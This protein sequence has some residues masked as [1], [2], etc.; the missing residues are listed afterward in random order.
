M[1]TP[2]ENAQFIAEKLAEASR[3]LY[4]AQAAVRATMT[5]VET[6]EN[7]PELKN[8]SLEAVKGS[9]MVTNMALAPQVHAWEG[10]AQDRAKN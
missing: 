5:A 9:I 10:Y 1:A 4:E 2:T 8:A 3:A 6:N 7:E